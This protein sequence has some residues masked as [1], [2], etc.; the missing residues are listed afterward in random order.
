MGAR[1][2]GPWV[3]GSS[4][5]MDFLSRHG[6]P[7]RAARK[8]ARLRAIGRENQAGS[9]LFAAGAVAVRLAGAGW[10]AFG[11]YGDAEI[12]GFAAAIGDLEALRRQASLQ[13]FTDGRR[14]AGHPAGKS[15]VVDGLKLFRGQHNLQ[16]LPARLIGTHGSSPS[17]LTMS[18]LSR[19]PIVPSLGI[20]KKQHCLQQEPKTYNLTFLLN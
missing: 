20:I 18:K 13:H 11:G 5:A 15:P 12:L 17:I 8:R 9:G 2:P 14:P 19:V 16:T 3:A 10:A 6:M 1:Q 7:C 4:P